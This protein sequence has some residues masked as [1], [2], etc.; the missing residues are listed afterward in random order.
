MLKIVPFSSRETKETPPNLNL[1]S[2]KFTKKPNAIARPTLKKQLLSKNK[3]IKENKLLKSKFKN[4]TNP[5]VFYLTRLLKNCSKIN[6]KQKKLYKKNRTIRFP[7]HLIRKTKP[8]KKN[9]TH[10]LEIPRINLFLK[11]MTKMKFSD[12][13]RNA[14]MRD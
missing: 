13:S 10:R 5:T 14:S 9:L 6:H 3:K 4:T 12:I 2:L 7:Q 11:M 8:P 1:N